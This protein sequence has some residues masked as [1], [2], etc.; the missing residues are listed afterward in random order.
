MKKFGLISTPDIKELNYLISNK[1]IIIGSDGLWDVVSAQDIIEFI[2]EKNPSFKNLSKDLTN[3]AIKKSS[4]DNISI[5]S[6][7]I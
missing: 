4:T 1:L 3:L 7:L 6:L 2:V 5:V